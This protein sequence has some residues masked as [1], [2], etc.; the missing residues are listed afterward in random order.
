[1]TTMSG[2]FEALA[3]LLDSFEFNGETAGAEASFY[4]DAI[5]EAI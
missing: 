2:S 5:A 1:M 3:T 4:V